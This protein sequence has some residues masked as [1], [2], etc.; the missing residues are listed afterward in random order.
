M[1]KILASGLLTLF[2]V[3]AGFALYYAYST[4]L[5]HTDEKL[6]SC[7]SRLIFMTE[8][9]RQNVL[10]TFLIDRDK[11]TGVASLEGVHTID[12]KVRGT[13]N[14]QVNFRYTYND[15][16]YYLTSVSLRKI[17]TETVS[18]ALARQALPEFFSTP[19]SAI[20]YTVIPQDRNISVFSIGKM[21]RFMCIR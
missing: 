6:V 2:S 4:R 8:H 9:S 17:N 20:N 10:L 21:P 11:N 13:F 1:K 15:G 14:R 5:S 18:D 3:S 16:N 12:N 7:T 19:G